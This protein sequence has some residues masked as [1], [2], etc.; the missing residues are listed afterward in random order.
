MSDYLSGKAALAGVMGWPVGHSLSPRLHGFWLRRHRIDGAYLPLAVAPDRLEQALRALPALGFRGA[1]LTIPH[2]EPALALVDRVTPA[3]KRIGA[4]NTVTV[5]PGGL[6]GDNTD[7]YGFMANLAAGAPAWRAADG[8]AVLLGAGG[9][10]RAI[11]AALI[12]AGVPEVR[13]V[14][15]TLARAET[16]ACQ[17]AETAR[18]HGARLAV[19]PWQDGDALAGASLMVNTTSLGMTGQRPLQVDLAPL[20]V[21]ALVTDIVYSPLET[22]LLAA[23]RARGHAVVDGLGMLLHQARPGFRAWFGV[24]PEVT[25]DLR[26]AVLGDLA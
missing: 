15:R 4:V 14:N 17:L 11:A 23:A 9:A 16:L 10:A 25:E 2:K 5:G 20:P 22:G 1:N 8:P 18:E 7:G 13:L 24:D 26:R 12:D 19:L 6:L 21:A 3:A